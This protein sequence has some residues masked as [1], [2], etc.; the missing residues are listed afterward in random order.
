MLA[1]TPKTFASFRVIPAKNADRTSGQRL[2][3]RGLRLEIRIRSS[4]FML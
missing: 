4:I 3:A 1:R 2:A